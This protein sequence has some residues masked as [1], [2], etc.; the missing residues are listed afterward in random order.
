MQQQFSPHSNFGGLNRS[1]ELA[2]ERAGESMGN[3][4]ITSIL[5]WQ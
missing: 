5:D 1:P 3:I 4:G 2:I